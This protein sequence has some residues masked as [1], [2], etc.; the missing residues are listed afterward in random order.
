MGKSQK[1]PLLQLFS[2]ESLFVFKKLVE[3]FVDADSQNRHRPQAGIS[4]KDNDLNSL[5]ESLGCSAQTTE[6]S[7]PELV[8]LPR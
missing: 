3:I 5:L 6:S 4:D 7:S 1:T 8:T 2:A